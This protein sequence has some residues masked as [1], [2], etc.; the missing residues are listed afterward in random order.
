VGCTPGNRPVTAYVEEVTI[1]G[2]GR[3]VAVLVRPDVMRSRANVIIEDASRIHELIA[4]AGASELPGDVD[5]TPERAEELIRA[6]RSGCAQ[7][8]ARLPSS[9]PP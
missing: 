6:V 1:T 4:A 9:P 8:T 5:L 7:W 3:P 2:H